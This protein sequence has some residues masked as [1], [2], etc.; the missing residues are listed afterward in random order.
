MTNNWN[1]GNEFYPI[2]YHLT[3]VLSILPFFWGY[4]LRCVH[5][6]KEQAFSYKPGKVIT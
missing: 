3:K 6:T 5:L 1:D 2:I 4:T